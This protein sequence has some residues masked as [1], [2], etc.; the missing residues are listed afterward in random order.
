[1]LDI[2]EGGA[3]KPGLYLETKVPAQFPA[4]KTTCASCWNAAA[5][6]NPASAPPPGMSTWPTAM[7]G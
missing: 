7:A 5:G 6:C 2:A 3:N 1:M 4:S